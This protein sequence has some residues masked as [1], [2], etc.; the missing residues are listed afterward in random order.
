MEKNRYFTKRK[1]TQAFL[2]VALGSLG[3]VAVVQ[4]GTMGLINKSWRPV[5]SLGGGASFV[6]KGGQSQN[7]PIINP[8]TDEFYNYSANNTAKTSGMFDA[9]LGIEWGFH[10]NW[11]LQF[12]VDYNVAKSFSVN[13]TFLQGMDVPSADSYTYHYQIFAQQVLAEGKLLYTV[14][15]RFHPYLL[16]GIGAGFTNAS[17][18]STNV[19]PFLTFTR[20]YA[21]NL[22]TSF[23]W[24]GGAGIDIAVVKH[25]RL[26]VGYRFASFGKANLGQASINGISV[27]GTLTQPNYYENQ[28]IGQF[29]W[30]FG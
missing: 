26:G 4:A 6:T 17:N 28:V 27:S 10:P 2:F 8:M 16:G 21:N 1:L 5:L 7:F 22:S 18:Y 24:A 3:S 20:Q 15:K 12:G 14:K 9:F 30:L 25:V 11:A 29:T 13:G 23:S 19:P